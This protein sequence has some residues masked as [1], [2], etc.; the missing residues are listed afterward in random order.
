MSDQPKNAEGQGG[1]QLFQ[2]MDEQERVYAP[3]EVP[4]TT[5]PPG[6]ADVGGTAASGTAVSAREGDQEERVEVARVRPVTGS[7]D[8]VPVAVPTEPV[9]EGLRN[10][11]ERRE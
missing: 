4:G 8:P 5:L 9:E 1:E 3:E 7:T 10:E 6:E 11:K 2:N